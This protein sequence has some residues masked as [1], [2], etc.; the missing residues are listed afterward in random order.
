MT[1]DVIKSLTPSQIQHKF[2]TT[3]KF[4]AD[5]DLMQEQEYGQEL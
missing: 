1:V 3:P 4:V 5:V 2:S